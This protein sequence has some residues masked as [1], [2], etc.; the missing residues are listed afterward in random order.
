[1]T[2][3]QMAEPSDLELLARHLQAI[4]NELREMLFHAENDR[5]NVRSQFDNLAAT[6]ASLLGAFEG[7]MEAGFDRIETLVAKRES[8]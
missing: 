4:R 8:K 2:R 6:L 5:R 1:M 7:R 3:L